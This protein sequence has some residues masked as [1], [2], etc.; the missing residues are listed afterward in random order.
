M[1]KSVCMRPKQ[2]PPPKNILT[3][4]TFEGHPALQ[5]TSSYKILFML[6]ILV[7]NINMSLAYKLSYQ[8]VKI[9]A[10]NFAGKE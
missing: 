6:I 5:M 7:V 9:G 8:K 10:T 4:S 2:F 3:A 1:R